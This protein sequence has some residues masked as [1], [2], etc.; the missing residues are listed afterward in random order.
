MAQDEK[1]RYI[2]WQDYRMMQ[3]SFV[4]NLF[5]TFAVASLAYVINLKISGKPHFRIP[6]ELT[7]IWWASSAM[8]GVFVTILRLLDY[9]YT[10]RKIRDGGRFNSFM[11]K[12]GPVTWGFLWVQILSYTYGAYLF[13]EGLLLL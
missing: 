4:I 7:I 2:R 12:C 9:R 11:A 6:F 1:E 3:K 13:I 8:A 5:L 10:A